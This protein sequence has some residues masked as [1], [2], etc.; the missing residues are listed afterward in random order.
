MKETVLRVLIRLLSWSAQTLRGKRE[1][2][3]PGAVR[4]IVVLQMSG[5]GDLLLI[6]PALRA[7]HRLYPEAQVDLITYRLTNAGFLYRFPYL[8]QGAEFPLFKLELKHAWRPGFWRRLRTPMGLLRQE[9]CDLYV[10]FHHTWMLQ[11]YL[12]ELWLAACSGARYTIGINPDFVSGPGVFDQAVPESLLGERHYR[13]FFLDVVRLLGDPGKDL[14]TEFPLAPG[15]I[16]T[17]R[18]RI[19]RSL[20]GKERIICLHVGATHKAQLWPIDRFI[21]LARRCQADGH[22]IVLIGTA[23]EQPLTQQ[24]ARS[25]PSGTVLDV[26]GTTTLFEMAALIAAADLFIGNDS[27]P[28]HVA[29]ARRR[30]TIGLIGPGRARYHRYSP[31]EAVIIRNPVVCDIQNMKNRAFP[32]AITVDDVYDK[33]QALLT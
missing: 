14:A 2:P 29:I 16:E 7:L 22:G 24:V 26:A 8:R 1:P 6:T 3:E 17:A 13:P 15:E 23:D 10:S 11:W 30:P 5:V 27:G 21:E 28:L 12:L 18:E 25:L 19:R 9:P 31:D 20:P 4:R 33:A 32:W